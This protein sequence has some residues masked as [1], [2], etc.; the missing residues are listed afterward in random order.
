[1]RKSLYCLMMA[2]FLAVPSMSVNAAARNNLETQQ[3]KQRQ[4][5]E[6]K[7]LKMRQHFM[8]QSMKGRNIPKA[9]RLQNKHQMQRE[10]R[11]LR[12]KQKDE[13]QDLKDRV[14]LYNESRKRLGQ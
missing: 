13:M 8:K 12:E 1:M 9:V 2:C 14:R 10:A 5:A 11:E 3:V 7:A 4:K 6:R